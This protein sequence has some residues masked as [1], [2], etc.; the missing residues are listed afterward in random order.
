MNR[1]SIKG[2]S[3]YLDWREGSGGTVEIFDIVVNSQRRVG[4]GRRMVY[5]LYKDMPKDTKL[6]WAITRAE[7][8]IA[9]RFYE[10]LRFRVVAVLRSFYKDDAGKE[11]VDAIM[12]GRDIGSQS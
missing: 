9:Q 7:N 6:V 5:Q 2:P 4:I 12:Y 11:T 8:F 1:I 3:N 10:E